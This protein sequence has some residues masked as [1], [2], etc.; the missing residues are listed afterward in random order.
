MKT[1][2]SFSKNHTSLLLAMV[3]LLLLSAQSTT[4]AGSATWDSTNILNTDWNTDGN[5][6]ITSGSGY[7]GTPPGTTDTAT[8]NNLSSTISLFISSS[9]I[10]AAID[11]TASEKHAFTITVDPLAGSGFNGT[12]I[13]NGS[14]ITQNFVIAEAADLSFT[15]SA[16]AGSMTAFTNNGS[17]AS[18]VSAGVMDFSD[19]STA[20]SATITNNGGTVSGAFGGSTH[21]EGTS[22]A[23][24]ATLIANGG[25]ASGAGGGSIQFFATSTGGTASVDVLNNG[26][27]RLAIWI[28]AVIPAA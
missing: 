5:W 12:G 24:S 20:G 9:I 8:F 26:T 22:T 23:G 1:K 25:T 27:A 6:M 13:T 3:T 17:T 2:F 16:T 28:S 4:F 21:F 15:N 14:G 11:F 18:G 7:P 10:I 19:T